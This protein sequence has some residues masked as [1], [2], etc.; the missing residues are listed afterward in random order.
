VLSRHKK[1]RIVG[2]ATRVRR[3]CP[4]V[5]KRAL[6]DDTSGCRS[7]SRPFFLDCLAFCR[8]ALASEPP[9]DDPQIAKN[10]P[11]GSC[12]FLAFAFGGFASLEPSPARACC[13]IVRCHDC[14]A[15]PLHWHGTFVVAGKIVSM[16]LLLYRGNICNSNLVKSRQ[17][18]P[19][20]CWIC[21]CSLGSDVRR[22][23]CVRRE[24]DRNQK[25]QKLIA[26]PSGAYRS[27]HRH[28][29]P[30]L[31]PAVTRTSR[32]SRLEIWHTKLV[33]DLRPPFAFIT[34]SPRCIFR[35]THTVPKYP[36][37]TITLLGLTVSR[38]DV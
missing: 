1:R 34:P 20:E 23:T 15:P 29:F 8:P 3:K 4:N 32:R 19:E 6:R 2:T 26:P 16:S 14:F 18:L 33:P 22:L 21:A 27:T 38:T 10:R 9:V 5:N 17:I 30:H 12:S 37:K 25:L 13:S 36:R 11:D 7:S 24:R 28:S 31:L 35:S